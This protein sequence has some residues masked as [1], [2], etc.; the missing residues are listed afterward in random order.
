MNKVDSFWPFGWATSY[1]STGYGV[2]SEAKEPIRLQVTLVPSSVLRRLRYAALPKVVLQ[3]IGFD[4]LKPNS[5]RPF[6]ISSASMPSSH[7]RLIVSNIS[8]F[9]RNAGVS[10]SISQRL[11]GLAI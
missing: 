5:P 11:F 6:G 7:M 9:R 3:G 4:G 10:S 1:P 2:I 8:L